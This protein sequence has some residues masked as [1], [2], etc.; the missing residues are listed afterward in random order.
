[1]RPLRIGI[2]L[3]ARGRGDPATTPFPSH[4]VMLED[5]IEVERLGFDSVWLPDHFYFQQPAGFITYPD[6]WTLLSALAVKTERITLGTNVIAATF[7][8]P[9]VLAKMAAALQD[10]CDGRFILGIGAGN[11]V[12][13][14]EAFGLDFAHRIGRFKE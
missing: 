14:H 12:P 6:V 5:G 11:Q 10:L 13:E 3:V 7:R 9:A 8:H 4:R 1:M 2:Q